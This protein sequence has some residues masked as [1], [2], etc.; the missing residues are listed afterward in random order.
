MKTLQ[1]LK[2]KMILTVGVILLSSSSYAQWTNLTPSNNYG[3]QDLTF[4]TSNI[5]YAWVDSST[6]QYIYKTQDAGQNWQQMPYNFAPITG[7]Y[8]QSLHFPAIDTGYL[9]FRG[10]NGGLKSFLY[11]TTDGGQSWID[12]T[13]L[14]LPVGTGLA[15][16]Y[17]VN[18]NNG[19]VLAGDAIFK[20]IDGG[21]N[22]TK[23]TFPGFS[24]LV[25][26]DF[27]D[28]NNGII[29]AWDG[30]FGY[31]GMIY[32]TTDGG[33]N[34]DSLILQPAYSQISDVDYTENNTAY[35]MT[36]TGWPPMQKIY[37]TINN[38][39]TW[40]TLILNLSGG[41]QALDMQFVNENEGYLST[42][43]GEVYITIDGGQNWTIDHTHSANLTEI[44][45]SSTHIFVSGPLNTLLSKTIITG[46]EDVF[47]MDEETSIYPNP[48]TTNGVLNF[49]SNFTGVFN[50]TSL[51]GQLIHS[52]QLRGAKQVSL[53]Q[54][55]LSPGVYLVNLIG[56]NNRTEKLII[57]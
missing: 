8:L 42:Q 33:L 46:I 3:F 6:S 50:L 14:N 35:A 39:A 13:P 25:E 36:I 41:D 44:E 30:T 21:D 4:P 11:K 34:W 31:K 55:N 12:K 24:E 51:T 29:G 40:D 18:S 52:E 37:K 16:V 5:G 7:I 49:N 22:W 56:D 23:T 26:A 27:Y 32:T 2:Q 20:T 38:G 47:N 48:N 15:N 53:N 1:N 10:N 54:F 45:I 9:Q 43:N 57:Q 28:L 19:Y 17:F